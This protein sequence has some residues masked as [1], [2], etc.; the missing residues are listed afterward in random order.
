MTTKKELLDKGNHE[1]HLKRFVDAYNADPSSVL[2]PYILT[3]A[4]THE[5]FDMAGGREEVMNKGIALSISPVPDAYVFG[6]SNW[7]DWCNGDKRDASVFY[8]TTLD[9]CL[10]T[11]R[12]SKSIDLVGDNPYAV[13]GE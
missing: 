10:N 2:L 7:R 13:D 6:A 3:S 5:V 8:N 4:L 9:L 1:K 12:A 11:L